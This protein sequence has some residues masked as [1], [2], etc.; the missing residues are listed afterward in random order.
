M[1]K[2]CKQCKKPHECDWKVAQLWRKWMENVVRKTFNRAIRSRTT[3]Q[4]FFHA[5]RNLQNKLSSSRAHSLLQSSTS[6]TSF[7]LPTIEKKIYPSRK[8]E[9]I[10]TQNV[11]AQ[12]RLDA[13]T[14]PRFTSGGRNDAN[15]PHRIAS[16]SCPFVRKK[17][18]DSPTPR[19]RARR[20]MRPKTKQTKDRNPTCNLA[21]LP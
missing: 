10:Q 20:T 9:P 4:S 6:T 13:F 12:L 1:W 15:S 5:F 3:H 8:P 7:L 21:N 19:E 16:K 18:L 17:F 11:S 2:T 14:P